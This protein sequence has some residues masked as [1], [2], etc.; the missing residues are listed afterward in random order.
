[1]VKLWVIYPFTISYP[2]YMISMS[3]RNALTP[4]IC[5]FYTN[6]LRKDLRTVLLIYFYANKNKS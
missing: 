2:R 6:Y 5:L 3:F 4:I 1:M